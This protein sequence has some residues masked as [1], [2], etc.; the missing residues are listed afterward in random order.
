MER[1]QSGIY[2]ET[3]SGTKNSEGRLEVALAHQIFGSGE[4]SAKSKTIQKRMV[5][6][7]V[8]IS[9]VDAESLGLVH[10][11]SVSVDGNG[12]VASVVIRKKIKA[13]TVA[14]Y[15]GENEIDR[16]AIGE[17]IQLHKVASSTRRG[18]GNLIVSDLHEEGY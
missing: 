15:C 7:Y 12:S 2:L 13:G 10:G 1:N 18:L 17:T 8:G 5:D 16:Y 9:S 3:A 4:L 6:P 11:D 14:L